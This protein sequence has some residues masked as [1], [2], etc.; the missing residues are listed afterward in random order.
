MLRIFNDRSFPRFRPSKPRRRYEG[1]T[2]EAARIRRIRYGIRGK[3]GCGGA[4]LRREDR[5]FVASAT[6]GRRS[7]VFVVP[8]RAVLY[9]R[10]ARGG[11][12]SRGRPNVHFHSHWFAP[13]ASFSRQPLA[14]SPPILRTDSAAAATRETG[15]SLFLFF[16]TSP[17][18][19]PFD[20][21]Y[22]LGLHA[23]GFR[24]R[25]RVHTY[26]RKRL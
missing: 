22:P 2:H 11:R 25:S 26:P 12:G 7:Y 4:T 1:E 10:R 13:Y 21:H 14:R 23:G 3:T 16:S 6:L 20:V 15:Y 18:F 8:R 24:F 9:R 19:S 5:G 17:L